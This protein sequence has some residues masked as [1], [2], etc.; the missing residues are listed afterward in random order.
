ML[1]RTI[2]G[3]KK[4]FLNYKLSEIK[5]LNALLGNAKIPGSF[6]FLFLSTFY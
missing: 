6:F 5:Q 3:K 4:R 1:V 2:Y